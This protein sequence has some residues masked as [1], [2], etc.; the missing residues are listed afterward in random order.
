MNRIPKILIAE[1]ENIIAKDIEKTLMKLG[2]HVIGSVRSGEKLLEQYPL[3]KPDLILMDINLEGE[4]TGIDVSR[5]LNKSREVP[6]IY[7]T[8]LADNNTLQEAK[9]TEPSGYLIKPFDEDMLRTTIEMGL[10][11]FEIGRRLRERTKELE[12]ERTKS[13]KLLR[14]IL[15][16]E[17]VDEFKKNGNINP[18]LYKNV[19]I[20]F[21]DFENFTTIAGDMTPGELVTELNEVFMNFDMIIEKYKLE[22]LKTIGDSYM[23]ASGLPSEKRDHAERAVNC[24]FEMLDYLANRN[25]YSDNKWHMR[26]GIHSG[27]VIAGIVGKFKYTYDVWG[28]SVSITRYLER[29]GKPGKINISSSVKQLLN[30]GFAFEDSGGFNTEEN[31]LTSFFVSKNKVYS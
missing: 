13:D 3:L 24:A 29:F 30:N 22:K 5:E 12:D 18:R 19:T 20:I 15:P 6:V 28:E 10:Y 25:K 4:L 7:L 31:N 11:K 17:I 8:A 14:D 21:T 9:Y 1:D 26:V 16:S 23:I 2:Y 27:E